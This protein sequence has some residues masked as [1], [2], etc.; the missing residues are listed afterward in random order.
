M[1]EIEKLGKK[2]NVAL[3]TAKDPRVERL[4]C[5]HTGTYADDCIVQRVTQVSGAE[6]M[7]HF[8]MFLPVCTCKKLKVKL[9]CKP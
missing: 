8:L 4:P 3:R 5:M 6:M 9:V 1:A 7:I 2:Y